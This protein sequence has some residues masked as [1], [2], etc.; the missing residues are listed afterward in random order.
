MKVQDIQHRDDLIFVSDSQDVE[1]VAE[2]VPLNQ[3]DNYGSYFVK[4][5]EGDYVEIYGMFGMVP[6]LERSIYKLV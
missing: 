4:V 1:A 2:F 6:W 3:R 5:N